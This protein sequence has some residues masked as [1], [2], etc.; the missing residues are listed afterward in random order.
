MCAQ[1]RRRPRAPRNARRTALYDDRTSRRLTARWA[2]RPR[3][4]AGG[5]VIVDATFRRRA[6][7]DAFF[8]ALGPDAPVLVVECRAPSGVLLRRAVERQHEPRGAS[9]ADLDVVRAQA[10]A[11]QPLDEIAA[12]DHRTVRTDQPT[13]AVVDLIADAASAALAGAQH[14]A[15][16][17]RHL[18]V[19][20]RRDHRSA[21]GRARRADR[22]RRRRAPRCAPRPARRR[23][24]PAARPRRRGSR[25]RA[26]RRR[27]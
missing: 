6:D 3:A 16:L 14:R 5:G 23:G 17:P 12:R 21:D 9:D 15:R 20:A 27:R 18:E 7:R 8:R 4:L 10:G 13:A 24:T 22:P 26:R 2:T 25:A 1:A 11:F 19:L